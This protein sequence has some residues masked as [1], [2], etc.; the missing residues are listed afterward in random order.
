MDSAWWERRH[1]YKRM[2]I[3]ELQR[4]AG[5]NLPPSMDGP[6]EITAAKN[7]GI[8]P[9]FIVKDSRGETYIV[10]FDPL[11]YS[12]L[13]TGADMVSSRIFHALGYHVPE[14]YIVH[15][16]PEQLRLGDDV[17]LR[18]A[19]GQKRKIKAPETHGPQLG[20]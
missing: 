12:E 19:L 8:T 5:K 13:A 10:K 3:D 6:W 2:S 15:F 11:E 17:E 7:E 18:D 20:E 14:Y 9:G 4:G 1:Y 16:T